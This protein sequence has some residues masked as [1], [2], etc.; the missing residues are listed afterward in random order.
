MSKSSPFLTIFIAFIS[1]I[2]YRIYSEQWT[3]VKPFSREDFEL[4]SNFTVS[5]IPTTYY[6]L[7][8]ISEHL[9]NVIKQNLA[10]LFLF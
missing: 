6:D 4:R 7:D 1:Y 9:P 8:K 5:D 3:H 2:V 10:Y